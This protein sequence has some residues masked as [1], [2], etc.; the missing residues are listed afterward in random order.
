MNKHTPLPWLKH[1]G[2]I[3]SNAKEAMCQNG[4]IRSNM[5]AIILP[6]WIMP[7][8]EKE[9][10]AEFIFKACNFHY[11]LLEALKKVIAETGDTLACRK[12][13]AIIE[14]IEGNS[15]RLQYNPISPTEEDEQ[16]RIINQKGG[17]VSEWMTHE[18]F[19]TCFEKEEGQK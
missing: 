6:T 12:A 18:K 16:Y 14:S 19:K 5:V 3:Y 17:Y 11:E 9:A 10:N 8:S 1:D 7:D 2:S 15:D 4:E 13:K